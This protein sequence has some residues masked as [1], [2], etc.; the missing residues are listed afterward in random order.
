MMTFCTRER[1]TILLRCIRGG[2]EQ[3]GRR[4]YEQYNII[5]VVLW[6]SPRSSHR[7]RCRYTCTHP[8]EFTLERGKAIRPFPQYWHRDSRCHYTAS[9]YRSSGNVSRDCCANMPRSASSAIPINVPPALSHLLSPT[10][11]H[12]RTPRAYETNIL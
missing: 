1:N 9:P 11:A 10:H 4:R 7:K 12:T 6:Q 3:S 2:E 5:A 8:K